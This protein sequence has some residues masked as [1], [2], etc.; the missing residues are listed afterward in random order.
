VNYS[1]NF[2]EY[3]W[4]YANNGVDTCKNEWIGGIRESRWRRCS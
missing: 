4:R 3:L 2:S 1:W